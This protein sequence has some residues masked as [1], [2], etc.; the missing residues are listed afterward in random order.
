MLDVV[1]E[2][3]RFRVATARGGRRRDRARQQH[4]PNVRDAGVATEWERQ[5]SDEF[6]PVVSA[7]IVRRGDLCPTIVVVAG[8]R[9]VHLVGAVEA[10]V[11][12]IRA[13]SQRAL[14]ERGGEGGRR[15]PHVATDGDATGPSV[16]DE[17]ASDLFGERLVH[18]LWVEAT[19]IVGLEDAG[20]E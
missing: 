3:L 6:D 1:L 11:D 16:G 4:V 5:A 15:E 17:R 14:D 20:G 12:D 13:L 10:D 8:H 2:H 9:E 19:H 18:F 7:G